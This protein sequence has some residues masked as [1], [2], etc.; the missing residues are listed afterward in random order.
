M[1]DADPIQLMQSSIK[2]AE[3]MTLS[4]GSTGSGAIQLNILDGTVT[5]Q[6]LETCVTLIGSQ[7]RQL[8]KYEGVMK[9]MME[10]DVGSLHSQI[11]RH[12]VMIENLVHNIRT[13]R[14]SEASELFEHPQGQPHGIFELHAC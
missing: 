10:S 12:Q 5:K 6:L 13:L 2:N 8:E 14:A 4:L 7:A 1:E 3:I 9:T 11:S